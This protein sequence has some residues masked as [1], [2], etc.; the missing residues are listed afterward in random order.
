MSNFQMIVYDRWGEKVFESSDLSA[1]WDGTYK[2]K[3]LSPDVFVYYIKAQ[4]QDQKELI[5]KGNVSLIN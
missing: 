5:K 2:G 4:S 1:C 3:V